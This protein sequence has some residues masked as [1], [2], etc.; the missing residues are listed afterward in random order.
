MTREMSYYII[1]EEEEETLPDKK[2]DQGKPLVGQ[3]KKDFPKALLGVADIARYGVEKYKA[4]GSWRKV[5]DALNRYED[6]LG[7]HDLM[8]GYE[9]YDDESG[10]LHAAH[11]A[12][13]A[14]ATL[15]MILEEKEL[16]VSI[17]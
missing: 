9:D 8:K 10:Y 14:L 6:A 1:E 11:R 12:W 2:Y 7:R 16:R 3:M 13:N 17:I 4:P 15:E 5:P